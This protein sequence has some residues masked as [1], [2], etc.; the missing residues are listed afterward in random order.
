MT[1]RLITILG[2]VTL[3]MVLVAC[4]LFRS[5][6]TATVSVQTPIDLQPTVTQPPPPT[7]TTATPKAILLA[8][9]G[10]DPALISEIQAVM[11][12]L[13]L[14]SALVFEQRPE[15]TQADLQSTAI[16]LV[17][18]TGLDDS[19]IAGLSS[20]AP[21][22]QFLVVGSSGLPLGA[23][24]SLVRI[25]DYS[26]D[27]KAF[28]AGYIAAAVTTDWRVAVVSETSPAGKAA[29]NG[30]TNGV[31]FF[32]GLCRSLYPPFPIPAYPL[33]WELQP[34]ASQ[35]DWDPA[36][37]FFKTWQ[38]QTIYLS[39]PLAEE[40]TL[41]MLT[42][43]GFNL[44]SDS[45]TATG[46]QDRWIATISSANPAEAVSSLWADLLAG[47][48]GASFDLPLIFTQ[49][50]PT[51]FSP[52]KQDYVADMLADLLTG[53]IDTGVDPISGEMR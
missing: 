37:A 8:P 50:N 30:F 13:S 39:R 18:V 46:I 53:L 22:V 33:Y 12:D 52:G 47:K 10:A 21:H 27:V 44:I 23:N 14:K 16:R 19:I 9:P 2:M 35:A 40:G 26:P 34:G 41:L 38:V 51:L 11:Q 42:A 1:H 28:L 49:I 48:G 31:Y 32:C 17:V 36:I 4:N 25:R 20:A 24:L 15:L 6:S 29:R 3:S 7:V 43:A 45:N 5:Q